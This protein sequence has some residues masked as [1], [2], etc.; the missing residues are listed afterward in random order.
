MVLECLLVLQGFH[1]S[2]SSG[3][4]RNSHDVWL[5]LPGKRRALARAGADVLLSAEQASLE[6]SVDLDKNGPTLNC[7]I[8]TAFFFLNVIWKMSSISSLE[9]LKSLLKVL[10][11]SGVLTCSQMQSWLKSECHN[12][13]DVAA[14]S[15]LL[16]MGSR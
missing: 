12:T 7:I 5:Q 4:F 2:C 3:G 15:G 1:S 10:K 11:V 13:N 6:L 16:E 8:P 9:I 14:N